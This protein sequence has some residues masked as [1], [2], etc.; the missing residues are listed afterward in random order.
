MNDN[1][2]KRYLK[3]IDLIKINDKERKIGIVIER[4]KKPETILIW[5]LKSYEEKGEIFNFFEY[6][7][8]SR[9]NKIYFQN[10]TIYIHGT[11]PI[12]NLLNAL[13]NV[14]P[15]MIVC[16]KELANQDNK[17]TAEWIYIYKRAKLR[18]IEIVKI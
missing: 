10:T 11:T 4:Y 7:E 3:M 16:K 9:E 12:F 1:E 8:N 13:I 5:D 17:Q 2:R 14:N 15:R 18:N 6:F